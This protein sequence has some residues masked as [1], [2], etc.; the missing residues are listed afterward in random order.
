MSAI[1]FEARRLQMPICR[2]EAALD[3][4]NVSSGSTSRAAKR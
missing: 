3:C 4:A 1:W 2:D